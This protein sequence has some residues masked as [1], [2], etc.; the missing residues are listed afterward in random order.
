M[1]RLVRETP[2]NAENPHYTVIC[3]TDP[4]GG[5]PH[6]DDLPRYPAL[7]APGTRDGPLSQRT[8]CTITIKNPDHATKIS[9]HQA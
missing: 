9:I 4:Q 2:V 1:G 8:D 7:L 3:P 5:L 6:S